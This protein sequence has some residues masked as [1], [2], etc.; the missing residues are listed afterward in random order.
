M[1]RPYDLRDRTRLFAKEV[2]ALTKR[3]LPTAVN[4][5][6]VRQLIRS[7]GSVGANYLEAGDHLGGRDFLMKL[8][9]AK[10]EARESDYWLDLIELSDDADP[11]RQRMRQEA[12]ELVKI[13]SAM[14][15][16]CDGN[17]RRD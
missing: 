17:V 4:T 2:F 9:T 5:E 14:I 11:E 7:A 8:R 6:V 3:A 10:R 16:S 1:D 12:I 15:R 13:L